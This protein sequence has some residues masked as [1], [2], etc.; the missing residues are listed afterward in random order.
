ME[1]FKK[2]L[3]HA[4][5]EKKLDIHLNHDDDDIPL[6]FEDE[7]A[8]DFNPLDHIYADPCEFTLASTYN[9]PYVQSC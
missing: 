1:Q 9:D 5:G 8:P 2:K 4:S 7:L 3:A 6:H